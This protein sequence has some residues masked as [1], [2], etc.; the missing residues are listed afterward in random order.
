M[1]NRILLLIITALSFTGPIRVNAEALQ[2]DIDLDT[3]FQT[4]RGF[5]ASDAW[6]VEAVGKDWPQAERE[7]VAR[8]L[9]SNDIA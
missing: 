5:G 6:A 2:L 1:L 3:G 9:F 8:W 7:Q 4:I